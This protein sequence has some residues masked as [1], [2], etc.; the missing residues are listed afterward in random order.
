MII[1]EDESVYSQSL[2]ARLALPVPT[3]VVVSVVG[4][5]CFL[6]I[7]HLRPKLELQATTF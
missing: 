1:V 2:I 6:W 4:E 5:D 7:S 3:K